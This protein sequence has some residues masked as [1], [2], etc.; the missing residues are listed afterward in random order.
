MRR[1][2][3]AAVLLGLVLVP[4]TA[5]AAP[6]S[7]CS[8]RIE[9]GQVG[10]ACYRPAADTFAYVA[11]GA[12]HTFRVDLACTI[13]SHPCPHDDIPTCQK[14]GL[15]GD[16]YNVREDNALLPWQACLTPD[17]A[18]Q[19]NGLT[20]GFLTR[21]FKRLTWP[22]SRL[23]IQPPHGKTLVNLATNFLTHNTHPTTQHVTLLGQHI[24]IQATPTTYTW[25]FADG[26]TLTT[27]DPGASYPHLH[28]THHYLHPGTLHPSITT[29][30][31]GRFRLNHGTWQTIPHTLTIPGPTTTL[32]ILTATPHLVGY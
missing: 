25:H 20:P 13:T 12:G 31:Q 7:I 15:T 6:G 5:S 16:V 9:I 26:T 11:A 4:P 28:I 23:T 24:T 14:V 1:L 32:Q 8:H 3:A 22:A 10:A 29:T 27:H 21:A 2:L 19:I 17:Q 18:Q 30:Y